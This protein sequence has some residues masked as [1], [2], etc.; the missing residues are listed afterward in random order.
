MTHSSIDEPA[1]PLAVGE[2][3]PFPGAVKIATQDLAARPLSA[4]TK[5]R[6]LALDVLYQAELRQADPAEL[7]ELAL[8]VEPAKDRPLTHAI[9]RG[10]SEH[11]DEI[12]QLIVSSSDGDWAVARMAPI[13]RNLARIAVWE[14]RYSDRRTGVIIAEALRLADEFS[15]DNSARFLNGLLSAAA[16]RIEQNDGT[17]N[18][19]EEAASINDRALD[20]TADAA[21]IVDSTQSS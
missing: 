4:Q 7:L 21:E 6:K 3:P 5:A 19:S 16:R 20:E 11:R 2:H 10:V 15:T 9:V 12:D 14:M 1:L 18:T 13:D 17:E 8:A